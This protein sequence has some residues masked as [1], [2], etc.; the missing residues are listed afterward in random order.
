MI[1]VVSDRYTIP[2]YTILYRSVNIISSITLYYTILYYVELLILSSRYF[3]I[4]YLIRKILNI[5]K[6]VNVVIIIIVLLYR[7]LTTTTTTTAIR[8]TTT[9]TRHIVEM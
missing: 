1:V 3:R 8:T 4:Y 9:T 6:F 7:I 2:Y 5:G